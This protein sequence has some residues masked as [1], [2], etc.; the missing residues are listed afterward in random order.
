[1]KQ[2]IISS[3]LRESRV[4]V[5]E[6]NRL[7][8]LFIERRARR[9]LVG[10][11]YR[12]RV[13]NVLAGM[14][15][16]FVD[17][18]LPKNGFLYVDEVELP[19]DS[20][21]RPRKITQLLR[22]GQEITVQVIKDPMGTKGARL[23]MQLSL[24]G[25]FLVYL[26]G[27][28]MCGVSRK[29]SDSE[30]LRLRKLCHEMKPEDAGVIIRTAAEGVSEKAIGR[31]LKFL[32]K[33]WATVARRLE[34][35]GAPAIVYSE[36]E[37]PL[38]LVRDMFTEEFTQILVDD[39]D[40][41]KRLVGFLQATAPELVDRVE[42][43]KGR[44]P[45]FESHGVDAEVQAALRRR[46]DLPS[47]GYL[48]ID[49]AEALTVID[50]NTG[51]YVGK[52]FLEDTILKTNLE[53]CAEVVRQLRIRDVGGII[54]IDFIDLSTR[55]NREQV[56]GALESELSKDRTKTYVVELSPL[57]LV[58]MTRQNITDG[59]R[60]VM[61]DRCPTCMGEGVV[62]GD[63]SLA[64][65]IERR[66]RNLAETSAA[67]AFL[68]EVHPRV[69]E[70][71]LRDGG[72]RVKQLEQQ[73]GKV[74]SLEGVRH[75]REDEL[76]VS[77]EGSRDVITRASLPVVAGQTLGVTIDEVHVYNRRDGIARVDG[78]VICVAGAAE[79][80]GRQVKVSIDEATRHCAHARLVEG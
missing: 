2:L 13:E 71:L 29:L 34:T 41:M 43:Y 67:E 14:D 57:G 25:R 5:Y 70:V 8:E 26:P 24:A 62:L 77:A 12:G 60:G 37:L 74:F 38:R 66:L 44:T 17:I 52:K 16:A 65:S 73:T 30:R 35:V 32:T 22:A 69:T 49:K 15:A 54:V 20:D 56:L 1:M 42:L 59:L 33:M 61:T 48:V 7:A 76:N 53:A 50:V 46:V 19:E 51:R 31:D 68:V 63:E 11:I 79:S 28:S 21:A 23:T 78:Y 58:E 45:L 47:G 9:S 27:G 72:S 10:D 36:A 75:L 64:I 18:G 55:E 3:D 6:H 80:V 4:A 40:L 39:E